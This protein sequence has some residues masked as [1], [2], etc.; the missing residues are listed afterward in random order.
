[1]GR[2]LQILGCVLM[3]V[4]VCSAVGGTRRA[5]AGILA[6]IAR[7]IQSAVQA[8]A[9]P[10]PTP[11]PTPT[12]T[13]RPK[14]ALRS[15]GPLRFNVSGSLSLGDNQ[16]ANTV[17]SGV[18]FTPTPSPSPGSTA[19]PFPFS[20]STTT[21][22]TNQALAG[23]GLSANVSR[24]TAMTM[25]DLSIPVGVSATGGSEVGE[26]QFLYS[27]PK[28]E[29]GYGV[30]QLLALGQLQVGSTLRGV[31][32]IL[33][34]RYGQTTFFEGPAYGVDDELVR[35]DGILVQQARG[36][37]LLEGGVVYADGPLTGHAETVDFGGAI[38]G[39]TLGLIAEGAW[40]TRSGG[41]ANAHGL[42]QQMRLDDYGKSGQCSTSVR[43]VPDRFVSF[44]AGEIYSDRYADVNCHD[45]KVPIYVDVNWEKSGDALMGVN[46]QSVA[47]IGYSPTTR[48]GG[49]AFNLTRQVGSAS[50]EAFS[51]DT[52]TASFNTIFLNTTAQVGGMFERS[53]AAADAYDT[54][55]LMTSLRHALGKHTSVGVTGQVQRQSEVEGVASPIAL[56]TPFTSAPVLGFQRGISF[57]IT[58]SF[59]RTTVQFG[60]TITRTVSDSSDALQRTPLINLTRQ[61]SP[62]ISIMT[63]FGYQ[64][65]RDSVNPAADGHSRIFAISLSAPFSY[66]N[67]NVTGHIDPRLPATI[68]G[69]VLFASDNATGQGAASNFATFAGSG[70]VSN[71][72]VTL[73]NKYV[74]RTDLNGGFQ[75]SFV[76]P[77]PHQVVVDTSSIPSGFTASV[78]VQNITVEGGQNATMSFIVGTFGGINGHV[79]GVDSN[80]N[81][82]PLDNV[83]LRVDGNAYAQTDREGA[84]AFGGLAA[85]TH[86]V[87]IIPQTIPASADFDPAA[88]TQ[89]VTVAKG[90]YSKLDFH[91]ELLG[92][93][94]G[95]ILYAKDMDNAAGA[96]VKN[97]YVVAE[98]GEHAAIDEDDGSFIIDDLP[99]GDYT[100]SVDPETLLSNLGAAPESVTIHLAPGEHYSGLLFTVG[101]F[102]KKVVFSLVGGSATPAPTLAIVHLSETRLPP[103]GTTNVAINAPKDAHDVVASAFGK[104]I[105]LAY[106]NALDKWLGE[107]EVPAG[108]GAGQYPV[109]GSV[110]GKALTTSATLTVDPKMPLVIVEFSPRV[111]GATAL[112]RARFLVDAHAGERIA[113]SDGT[114]TI[115]DKPVTGRVFTFRK[116][117]TL[118]PLHGLLLTPHGAIP[119]E[120]L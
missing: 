84:Y 57:D 48:F 36:R 44:S 99:A 76:S 10:S 118:L 29:V 107:L 75:F 61:L 91:A 49:L 15:G 98:P 40:Q 81:P 79:Y 94:A 41:D 5:D 89:K 9:N 1:M 35:L 45:T 112:V 96:A 18:I 100:V 31:S 8:I 117:L 56:A 92:S 47:T 20:S 71:V 25:T 26:P 51:S 97:A 32:F 16:S 4:A 82:I 17:G 58:Q 6:P 60:D 62:V 33:P 85:G 19:G 43:S 70:G 30:Q 34:S 54:E 22:A 24:R 93:I 106:D 87:T 2:L 101:R 90:D 86:E 102:E 66:G 67:S 59:K 111:V 74:E 68:T 113:W 115:L 64:T 114:S 88:L 38:A 116:E 46:N 109:T 119:I 72:L 39:H 83:E 53:V 3:L 120:L 65:L 78:P 110:Q 42:A 23:V 80:G 69:R 50:G 28:Y 37:A 108:T 104:P 14:P 27:T 21:S 12:P 13:P 63:S 11:V 73:D 7:A 52:G 105:D 103:H 55:S 95:E 77:G